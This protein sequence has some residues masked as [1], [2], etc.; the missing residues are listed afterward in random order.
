MPETPDGGWFLD[1]SEDPYSEVVEAEGNPYS[2]V[3][4]SRRWFVVKRDSG[5]VVPGGDHGRDKA[6]ALAHF[7]AL[8]MA[9]H[10]E[11]E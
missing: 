4:R 3:R 5:K 11:A 2:V 8:E 9:A 1:D 10:G 6:K 7:R